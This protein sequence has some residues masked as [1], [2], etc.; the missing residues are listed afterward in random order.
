MEVEKILE[1]IDFELKNKLTLDDLNSFQDE[2][3]KLEVKIKNNHKIYYYLGEINY[4][5]LQLEEAIYYFKK[6]FSINNF[7]NNVKDKITKLEKEKFELLTYLTFFDPTIQNPNSIIIA[8]K[9]LQKIKYDFNP[10][11]KIEDNFISQIYSKIKDELVK[12]NIDQNLRYSQTFREEELKYQCSRHHEVFFRYNAIPKYCFDCYKIQINPR[13]VLE[14]LK[15]YFV[16][17]NL[18]FKKKLFRKC[19]V[20]LRKNIEGT[21]KGLIYCIGL[22]EAELAYQNIKE[23]LFKTINKDIPLIIKRGCA[24]FTIAY[25]NYGHIDPKHKDFMNYDNNWIKYEEMVDND[26]SINFP[27]NLEEKSLSGITLRDALVINNWLYYAK[28]I[29]DD[30]YKVIS[31]DP[32]YSEYIEEKLSIKSY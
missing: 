3:Q 17:D 14:L 16:F 6:S 9:D 10:Q 13:S 5:K 11:N 29:G 4:L 26:P 30:T 7:Y 23:I 22:E 15:L 12:K 27:K 8:N 25:P 18:N 21:Y 24:E 28:S 32:I 2:L 20:E 19:M 1:K 31:S